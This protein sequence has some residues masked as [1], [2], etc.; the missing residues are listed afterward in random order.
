VDTDDYAQA[1]REVR[2]LGL[3]PE[4]IPHKKPAP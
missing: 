4:R 3:D 1:V 2:R